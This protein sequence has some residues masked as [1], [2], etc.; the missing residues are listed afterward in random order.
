MTDQEAYILLEK[1]R[2]G[3]THSEDDYFGGESL[4][5]G[6]DIDKNQFYIQRID[7]VVGSYNRI[8]YYTEEVFLEELKK[9]YYPD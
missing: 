3:D 9:W 5:F 1:I 8:D 6:F 7:T 2:K 4:T